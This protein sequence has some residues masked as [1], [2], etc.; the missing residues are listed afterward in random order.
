MMTKAAIGAAVVG[1]LAG[2]V[3]GRLGSTSMTSSDEQR[4]RGRDDEVAATLVRLESKVDR[5]QEALRSTNR[6]LDVDTARSRTP[7]QTG[8]AEIA[9]TSEPS[10]DPYATWSD[11]EICL[12]A[13]SKGD[14]LNLFKAALRRS[15]APERR[16]KLLV[17]LGAYRHK[18]EWHCAAEREALT[19]AVGLAM[20]TTTVGAEAALA[21]AYNY[22]A[23]PEDRWRSNAYFESVLRDAPNQEQRMKGAYGLAWRHERRA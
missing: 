8:I 14:D 6:Q 9:R 2:F 3:A 12:V 10:A 1:G 21:L 7:Q 11:D 4:S 23:T 20:T 15:L 5:L 17:A 22:A 16:A 19:E 13:Q 18:L